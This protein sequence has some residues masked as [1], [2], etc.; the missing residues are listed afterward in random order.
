MSDLNFGHWSYVYIN[1]N[2]FED[3]LC[4]TLEYLVLIMIVFMYLGSY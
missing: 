3:C 1:A 2:N 4:G